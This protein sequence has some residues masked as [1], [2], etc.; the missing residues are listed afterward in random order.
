MNCVDGL[1]VKR[2]NIIISGGQALEK[3]LYLMH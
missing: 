1:G 3:P 2:A